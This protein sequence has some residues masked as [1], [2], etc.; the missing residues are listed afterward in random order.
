MSGLQITV[1][2]LEHDKHPPVGDGK[3]PRSLSSNCTWQSTRSQVGPSVDSHS[4]LLES[5]CE[6]YS[7]TVKSLSGDEELEPFVEGISAVLWSAKGRRKIRL[8]RGCNGGLLPTGVESRRQISSLKALWGI[9]RLSLE[10]LADGQPL[11]SF[12]ISLL[13]A[14]RKS[15]T[16]SVRWHAVS[17]LALVQYNLYRSIDSGLRGILEALHESNP[18]PR[19]PLLRWSASLKKVERQMIWLRPSVW[20]LNPSNINYFH[21]EPPSFTSPNTKDTPSTVLFINE[22]S[23]RLRFLEDA[24]HCIFLQ[25]LEDSADVD[26]MPYEFVPTCFAIPLTNIPSF[27][28]ERTLE[29]IIST[30]SSRLKQQPEMHRID[31]II[32]L[33]LSLWK[34]ESPSFD[35]APWIVEYLT[36]R[37]SDEILSQALKTCNLDVLRACMT[38]YLQ[39]PDFDI[40]TDNVLKAI[41]RLCVLSRRSCTG[42]KWLGAFTEDALRAVQQTEVSLYSLPVVALIQC[43]VIESLLQHRME[44]PDEKT[45]LMAKLKVPI[46]PGT[47]LPSID[48]PVFLSSSRDI[49]GALNMRYTEACFIIL[50]D[51]LDG[52]QSAVLPYHTRETIQY[53]TDFAPQT[54]LHPSHQLR[55][56]SSIS[57]VVDANTTPAHNEIISRIIQSRMFNAY[58]R[59]Y[60]RS[61]GH[62]KFLDDPDA[63]TTMTD[64]L[65]S[66]A[67]TIPLGQFPTLLKRITAVLININSTDSEDERPTLQGHSSR[68]D[69][70]H[71]LGPEY[72]LLRPTKQ[73]DHNAR[74]VLS[75]RTSRVEQGFETHR[76]DGIERGTSDGESRCNPV[77]YMSVTKAGSACAV[78]A[79]VELGTAS[80][81]TPNPTWRYMRAIAIVAVK[82]TAAIPPA[83]KPPS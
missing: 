55:F 70:T 83:M 76:A 39:V 11:D 57:A 25:Y 56:A 74:S 27:A 79:D 16:A 71:I 15:A 68:R 29:R 73:K 9:S 54:K 20:L 23:D 5:V 50:T 53:I 3:I 8:L 40:P 58:A 43:E 24:P 67:A 26:S 30:H 2:F 72:R 45:L 41:W 51:F 46:L 6:L 14:L 64:A 4:K 52:C 61:Q 35:S 17:T 75:S 48:D 42:S 1:G 22:I 10:E 59:P 32:G 69:F 77:V 37:D 65:R 7:W 63:Q 78:L 13:H 44:T 28:I 36:S 19:P 34:P 66:Y 81:A 21:G 12:D 60:E 62:I 80:T 18:G 31:S 38:E 33:L 82:H 47:P 49:G